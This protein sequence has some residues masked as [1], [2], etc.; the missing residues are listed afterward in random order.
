MPVCV[1]ACK[2]LRADACVCLSLYFKAQSLNAQFIGKTTRLVGYY[3]H[4]TYCCCAAAV[5]ANMLLTY[6][7]TFCSNLCFKQHTLTCKWDDV[8]R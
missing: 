7:D 8:A 2:R 1:C 4:Y 6:G 3:Y 5:T